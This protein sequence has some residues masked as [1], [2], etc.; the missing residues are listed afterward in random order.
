L[1]RTADPDE[2]TVKISMDAAA[3][4]GDY[5]GP[6]SRN[7]IITKTMSVKPAKNVAAITTPTD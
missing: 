1:L 3:S 2:P 5:S 7:C 6:C 4:S